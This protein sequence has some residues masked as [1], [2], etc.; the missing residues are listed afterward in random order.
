MQA[1]SEIAVHSTFYRRHLNFG[2]GDQLYSD[3]VM[4]LLFYNALR[5]VVSRDPRGN[6]FAK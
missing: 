6:P 5:W 4:K 2:H 3:A 1:D